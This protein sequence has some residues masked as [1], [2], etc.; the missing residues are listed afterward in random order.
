MKTENVAESH[1]AAGHETGIHPGMVVLV[2]VSPVSHGYEFN[3]PNRTGL[4]SVWERPAHS[5]S[6]PS[7]L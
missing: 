1:Q 2:T 3:L 5:E 6:C 4:W 7:G